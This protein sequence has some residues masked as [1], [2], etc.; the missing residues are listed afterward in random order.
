MYICLFPLSYLFCHASPLPPIPSFLSLVNFFFV[1]GGERAAS[2]AVSACLS[3]LTQLEQEGSAYVA[4][5][6]AAGEGG[7]DA[8]PG[9]SSP[10][11]S[12]EVKLYHLANACLYGAAVLSGS[13]DAE[14][15]FDWLLS[16]CVVIMIGGWTVLAGWLAGWPCV[17]CFF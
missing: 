1:K 15:D 7:R 3:V 2:A 9:S 4:A 6:T 13:D 10:C 5:A 11:V 14:G 16:R 17:S 12:P 8:G